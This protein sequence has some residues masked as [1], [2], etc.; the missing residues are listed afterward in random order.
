[1]PSQP[2]RVK[3]WH[4]SCLIRKSGVGRKDLCSVLAKFFELC[5]GTQQKAVFILQLGF[6]SWLPWLKQLE[7]LICHVLVTPVYGLIDLV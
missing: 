3:L 7:G 4:E 1:M 2:G 6:K 5:R